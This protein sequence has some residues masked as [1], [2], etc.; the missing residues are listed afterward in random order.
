MP[1][2]RAPSPAPPAD[3]ESPPTAGPDS[4][5][6]ASNL[7][8]RRAG[9]PGTAGGAGRAVTGGRLEFGSFWVEDVFMTEEGGEGGGEAPQR[10]R[11]VIRLGQAVH[12]T[13]ERVSIPRGKGAQELLPHIARV[14]RISRPAG[15]PEAVPQLGLAYY[16]RARELAAKSPSAAQ[17][18]PQSAPQS[19]ACA[20][21]RLLAG[22]CFLAAVAAAAAP[23]APGRGASLTCVRRPLAPPFA[24]APASTAR[25]RRAC[26]PA[27]LRSAT[28]PASWTRTARWA[29]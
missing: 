13:N 28:K 20:Q 8:G 27:R 12:L 9:A 23:A 21:P 2:R 29:R 3:G 7:E 26:C 6:Y 14:T 1:P 19:G 25:A 15:D 16:C 24:Q 11:R 5:W 18:M 22:R 4:H 17:K 10:A